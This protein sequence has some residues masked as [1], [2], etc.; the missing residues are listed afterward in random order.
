MENNII[1]ESMKIKLDLELP[2]YPKFIEGI[3]RAPK[4]ES[5]LSQKDIELALRNALRY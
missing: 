4:R 2:Q 1:E 3:R 5:D